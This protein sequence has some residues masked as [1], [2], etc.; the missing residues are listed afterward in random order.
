MQKEYSIRGILGI[1]TYGEVII[2]VFLGQNFFFRSDWAVIFSP[3][4]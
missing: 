3:T 4:N 1:G 2:L